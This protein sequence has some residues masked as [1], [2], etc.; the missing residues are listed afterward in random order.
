[1]TSTPRIAPIT[2]ERIVAVAL[3]LLDEVGHEGLTTRR[4]AKELGVRSPALYWHFRSK[5]DLLDALALAMLSPDNW[6]GPATPQLLPEEWLAARAHA[7]RK[8]LLAYRDGA[9]IH[10]GTLP[11]AELL[12][13]LDEQ[14]KTLVA[15]GLSSG[16]ALLIL[17]A[18]GRYTVGWVLEEQAAAQRDRQG[19]LVSDS[20]TPT[21][22]Q[23]AA[24]V[25]R[26]DPDAVFDFGLRAMIRGAMQP[27]GRVPGLAK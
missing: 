9:V 22:G 11:S 17:Q 16:D 7:F 6:P 23:A 18:I 2:R 25:S 12:P 5:R 27:Y 8:D 19:L 20:A 15:Y 26:L 24:I 13:R 1:M 21:L 4:L 10:A 14:I 3:A